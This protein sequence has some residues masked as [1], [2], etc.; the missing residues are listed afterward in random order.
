MSQVCLTQAADDMICMEPTTLLTLSS[1][2]VRD[3]QVQNIQPAKVDDVEF[4]MLSTYF[5]IF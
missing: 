2:V 4:C 5:S 1:K 3:S